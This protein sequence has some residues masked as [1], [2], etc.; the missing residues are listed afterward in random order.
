MI[1]AVQPFKDE[2]KASSTQRG[3]SPPLYLVHVLLRCFAPIEKLLIGKG[4][5]F[6]E[7]CWVQCLPWPCYF[8]NTTG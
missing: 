6:P 7:N 3:V 2:V 8:Q 4:T 5:Y 1:T